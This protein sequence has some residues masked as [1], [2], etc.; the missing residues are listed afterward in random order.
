[1]EKLAC[2]LLY[3]LTKV[4]NALSLRPGWQPLPLHVV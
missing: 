4:N 3:Q 1:M 2:H